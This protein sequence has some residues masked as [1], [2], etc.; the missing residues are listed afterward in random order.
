MFHAFA[1][2]FCRSPKIFSVLCRCARSWAITLPGSAPTKGFSADVAVRCE[3]SRQRGAHRTVFPLDKAHV[4]AIEA[5][6]L[7]HTSYGVHNQ[8]ER[9]C[10]RIENCRLA[11]TIFCH[12]HCEL[13]VQFNRALRETPEVTQAQTLGA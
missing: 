11:V 3:F 6:R 12:Q 1:Q 8:A 7:P 5:M 2:L 4:C 10:D 9:N 13:L